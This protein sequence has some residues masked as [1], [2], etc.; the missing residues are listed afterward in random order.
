[1]NCIEF[2]RILLA[3]PGA[4]DAAFAEH[5]RSCAECA[6]AV[7]RSTR[8]EQ[9]LREAVSIDVP[10]NLASSILLKQSFQSQTQPSW[11][12]SP[13]TYALA[14]SMLLVVGLA[15]MGLTTHLEQRR[16]SEEFVALINGAPYALST[17]KPVSSSEISAALEPAGLDLAGTIGDVTFVG[18]CIVRGKI[19]GHIVLQGDTAP[20]TVFLIKEKLIADRATIQSDHYSGIVLAQGTGTIA[21][22]S[23]PG[24]ALEKIEARVRSAIRWARIQGA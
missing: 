7:E 19:S 5:R 4:V 3:D 14:A 13:R 8:F 23:S 9:C 17:R 22:V 1:M 10:E 12:R 6:D 18:R 24:E 11:W 21:I 20:V 16:L 2:R 15:Y